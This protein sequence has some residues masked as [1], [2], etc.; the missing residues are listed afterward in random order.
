MEDK[1]RR[2]R[3]QGAWAGPPKSQAPAQPATAAKSHLHQRPGQTWMNKEHRLAD[4]QFVFKEPQQVVRRAPEPR[5]IDKEGVYEISMSPTGISR[6]CLYPGFINLKE[7]DWVLVQL[8]EVV[9]WKQRTGIR[10]VASCAAHTEGP[11]RRKHWPH[12]QLLALQSVPKREGQC[13]LAQRR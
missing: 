4:R 2:A 9:P 6:V 3:V 13:R 7:A 1:R 11:N 12:L 8:C 10:D 5:V